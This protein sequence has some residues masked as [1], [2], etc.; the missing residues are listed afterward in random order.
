M[1]NYVF[2]GFNVVGSVAEVSSLWQSCVK[3]EMHLEYAPQVIA[4]YRVHMEV[5]CS[6]LHIA[7]AR[8]GE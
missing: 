7:V 2:A 5:N 6:Y 3:G 8:E 4:W 1:R